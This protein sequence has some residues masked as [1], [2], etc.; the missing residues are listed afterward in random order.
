MFYFSFQVLVR[1]LCMI[2]NLLQKHSASAE[3]DLSMTFRRNDAIFQDQ[4]VD[5]VTNLQELFTL[6]LLP[7]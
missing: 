7:L 1:Q 4:A 6:K 3:A 5:V 2:Y